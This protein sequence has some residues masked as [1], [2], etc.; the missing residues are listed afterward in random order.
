MVFV[1]HTVMDFWFVLALHSLLRFVPFLFFAGFKCIYIY[2]NNFKLALKETTHPDR[3][4][5]NGFTRV[6]R[7][8]LKRDGNI[9]L[10][11]NP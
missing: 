3:M 6:R 7:K 5:L 2:E 8:L 10:T 4:D 1:K 9:M 11:A